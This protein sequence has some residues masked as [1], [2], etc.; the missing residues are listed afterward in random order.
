MEWGTDVD[1]GSIDFG[2]IFGSLFP[3]IE[4]ENVGFLA[5]LQGDRAKRVQFRVWRLLGFGFLHLLVGRRGVGHRP[6]A[7][8]SHR[9]VP[10]CVLWW[11]GETEIYPKWT[12]GTDVF[13]VVF[14]KRGNIVLVF[15]GGA[16][17]AGLA[18][19]YE[20]A[21]YMMRSKQSNQGIVFFA[22]L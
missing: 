20:F 15:A 11:I 5:D 17:R 16:I 13:T 19:G 21:L 9:A 7:I 10:V 4:L 14:Q 3:R 22:I 18:F 1:T 2:G 8:Q 6:S 12:D